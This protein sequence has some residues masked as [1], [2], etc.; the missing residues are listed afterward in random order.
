MK[1]I[2]LVGRVADASLVMERISMGLLSRYIISVHVTPDLRLQ[3]MRIHLPDLHRST[4]ASRN[5]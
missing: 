1:D 2:Q 5:S 4:L 3:P